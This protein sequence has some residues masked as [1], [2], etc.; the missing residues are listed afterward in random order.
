[1]NRNSRP[2]IAPGSIRPF[3]DTTIRIRNR[4]GIRI[5]PAFSIPP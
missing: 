1:M 5:L 4:R 2:A 3:T